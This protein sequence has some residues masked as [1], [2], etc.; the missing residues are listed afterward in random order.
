MSLLS[1][2]ISS[3]ILY[4]SDFFPSFALLQIGGSPRISFENGTLE[5]GLK[6]EVEVLRLG[7]RRWSKPR[8]GIVCRTR[9][10][11]QRN[12]RTTNHLMSLRIDVSEKSGLVNAS[13]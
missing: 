4:T 11:R 13:A 12:A 7:Y 3:T 8:T 9:Q 1:G 5:G 10:R 6:Y 2:V